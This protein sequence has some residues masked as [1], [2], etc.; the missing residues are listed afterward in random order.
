MHNK[1]WIK[2]KK[3]SFILPLKMQIVNKEGITFYEFDKL[4]QIS[5]I[6]H[7]ITTRHGGVSKG[8]YASLNIG[9]GTDDVS[10]AVLE[11]RH[12]MADALG[13][14][15]D[16]FVMANQVHGTHVEVITGK[17]RGLGAFHNHNAILATDAM[18][19]DEPEICL[20]VMAADCVPLLFF[21]PEKR[22]IGATHA[23]W[24]GTVGKVATA[25]IQKMQEVYGCHPSGIFAAIGPSIGPSCY[26]VGGEVI[27]A[28][29]KS[30]GTTDKFINF[31]NPDSLP[32]FDLWYTNRYEL[33][34]AGLKDEHIEVAGLCTQCQYGDFFSS[35]H[36]KGITGRFGAGI[37][38][39]I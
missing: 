22:V 4:R 25:T 12:R 3:I 21:D 24:R 35:R 28:V 10:L 13:F 26:V 34:E 18:I 38:I 31:D 1:S 30:Y 9:F 19:T 37:M 7:F 33:L 29:L 36:G 6:V 15:L 14:P 39:N 2:F 23:G 8:A 32:M 27:D 20:F 17:H 16:Y 5:G 11:N